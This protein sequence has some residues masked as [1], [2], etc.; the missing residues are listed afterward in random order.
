MKS[1]FK[2]RIFFEK[3]KK[4]IYYCFEIMNQTRSGRTVKPKKRLGE[5]DKP[6]TI[7]KPRLVRKTDKPL[8]KE[9]AR[10]VEKTRSGRTVKLSP[11]KRMIIIEDENQKKIAIL[12]YKKNGKP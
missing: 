3:L 7:P 10:P 9:Q 12:E 11:K 8:K 1:N 6:E 4:Y 2:Y 5:F